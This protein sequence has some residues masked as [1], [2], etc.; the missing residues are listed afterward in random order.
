M[1]V[2][3]GADSIKIDQHHVIKG[4]A[5]KPRLAPLNQLLYGEHTVETGTYWHDARVEFSAFF[6]E[7]NG[8]IALFDRTNTSTASREI[9]SLPIRELNVPSGE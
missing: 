1:V 5:L 3:S 4:E 9:F 8:R 6:P 7:P 2:S